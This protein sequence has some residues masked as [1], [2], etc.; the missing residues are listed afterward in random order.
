MSRA[1]TPTLLSL[2]RYARIMGINPVH[3][4]G[5]VGTATIFPL[6]GGC[7][8]VWF[9]RSYQASDRVSR[10]DLAAAIASAEEDIAT[11]LGYWPAP[12][13]I[14]REMH[15]YPRHHRPDIFD[16]G[17]NTRGD[18]KSV[19]L[20]WGRFLAAGRRHAGFVGQ[21]TVAGMTLVWSDP[22]GDMFDER[23]TITLP[24]TLTS[25]SR[26]QIKVYFDG[27]STPEWE[28]RPPRSV[29]IAAGV[30][31][32]E[33][34]FWQLIDPALQDFYPVASPA[35]LDIDVATNYVDVLD[36]YREYTDFSQHSAEFYWEP[37]T[38][39]WSCQSCAGAGC[40]ACQTTVQC[41][42]LHVRD[43]PLGIAV[44]V[45][46]VWDPAAGSY[47]ATAYTL[48]YPPDQVKVWYQAGDMSEGFLS[49]RDL[50]PLGRG[51][52]EMIAYMATARLERKFCS[53][54]NLSALQGELRVD[55]A[56]SDREGPSFFLSDAESENPFGT[57]KG[58]ILAWRRLQK[59]ARPI[60]QVAVI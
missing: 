18:A 16:R 21:A 43:V 9:Q 3:F 2:D 30:L 36:V 6:R 39:V 32:I 19:Q 42:C 56:R 20:R 26:Q 53:C 59:L 10:E 49:S 11:Y 7:S 58:E 13:W 4:N 57:H 41:G 47:T 55:M 22:D 60:P 12:V 25:L 31:T 48:C 46:A 33:F 45:P 51:W 38:E 44:P 1:D 52:A 5:A 50:D 40:S 35:A 34:D 17:L 15:P 24:T 23:A 37:R 14:S 8:D 27:H 28:V 29:A 54:G